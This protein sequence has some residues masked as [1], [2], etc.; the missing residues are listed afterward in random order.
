[1]TKDH[2]SELQSFREVLNVESW[3]FILQ[4]TVELIDNLHQL[5]S[6]FT[7]LAEKLNEA[8]IAYYVDSI[9]IMSDSEYDILRRN[10]NQKITEVKNLI[11]I[12]E[13]I[14]SE[15][16]KFD[17]LQI[18]FTQIKKHLKNQESK[19][20]AKPSRKF[21][22]V[23][24]K[25]PMLSLGNCFNEDELHQFIARVCNSK[26]K[27]EF[28]CELKIDGVSFS[29][30]YENGSLNVSLTRGD[31]EIG[32]DITCNVKEINNLPHTIEYK[33]LLEIRGEIYI[34]KA[35]F[36]QLNENSTQKFANPRNAASGSV[37]QLD[38][39]ITRDRKLKYF[40]WELNSPEMAFANHYDK[41]IFAKSLGFYV[42]EHMQVVYSIDE[43][44]NFYQDI[45][46]RRPNLKYEIDGIVYKINSTE[47]QEIL[48]NTS[49][50]P[51][52]AIAHKFPASEANTKILD[53]IIQIGRSG[54]LTPVAILEPIGI[55]GVMISR[56]TLHNAREL[57]RNDYR[58][59]DTVCVVRSGDVIPKI[60][61]K[62]LCADKSNRFEMPSRCPVCNSE[63]IDDK[64]HKICIGGWSCKAQL[65]ERLK[66]FVSRSAFN[67]IGLGDKQ[68]EYFVDEKLIKNYADI[69]RLEQ[70][71]LNL[72]EPIQKRH[73]W[74]E[75]SAEV[76]F[77]SINDSKTID[78]NKFI[79]S[80]SIPLI[81][82]E[83][84]TLITRKFHDYKTLLE[85]VN[86]SHNLEL[87]EDINGIGEHIAIS[88]KN[89]FTN[90]YNL[91]LI[92]DLLPYITISNQKVD[93]NLVFAFTGKLKNFTRGEAEELIK[94][95]GGAFTSS[96]SKKTNYLVIGSEPTIH[97]V[98]KA[99]KLGINTLY[100]GDFIKIVIKS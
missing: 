6:E 97:K 27:M 90:D 57:Y 55:G 12:L 16:K 46:I 19:V 56:A 29:A 82:I 36:M 68:L 72:S 60:T 8:D 41:L 5:Y 40:V 14:I 75:K 32:E 48:G 100:E 94:K 62:I 80:L 4:N 9:P 33:G 1:M 71:N 67:I 20:G 86:S 44:L 18:I 63:V 98:E 96:I 88:I 23:K 64:V 31:G 81:G 45:A 3:D 35:G 49:S 95:S 52:W 38:P 66:H 28:V 21:K 61:K 65:V 47:K 53:I 2:L 77:T 59:G 89:F 76:L 91:H 37:R 17:D 83:V 70:V 78:F 79:Y 13:K 22:K 93:S 87:F 51:R 73:G 85:A 54:V 43:M 26:E 58:V 30:I 7:F 99:K 42:E 92:D 34:D 10:L 74:G 25:N 69:F 39:N 15:Q 50:A 11:K 24:H 84:A